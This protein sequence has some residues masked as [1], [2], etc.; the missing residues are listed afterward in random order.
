MAEESDAEQAAALFARL[1]QLVTADEQLIW[2]GRFLSTDL[3]IGIGP[4]PFFLEIREGRVATQER[5]P[6]LLRPWSLA[7]RGAADAWLQFW[8]PL[9]KPG[10]HDLSALAKRGEITIEG[11]IRCFMAN[12][13]YL[14][15][16]L[17]LPR[18]LTEE[19]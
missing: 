5:G 6:F 14:K 16:L 8:Q 3:M 12:L 9:P 10:W 17:A 11:D 18:R 2:R 13:Q 1:P 7:I 4:I 15:D 19:R